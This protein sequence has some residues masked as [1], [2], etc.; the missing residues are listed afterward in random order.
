MLAEGIG[1]FKIVGFPAGFAGWGADEHDDEAPF[2]ETVARL[3]IVHREDAKS[4]ENTQRKALGFVLNDDS[5][6]IDSALTGLLCAIFVSLRL[7][8]RF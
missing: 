4:A 7:C 5:Q 1:Q 6:I 2:D 8:G 3:P